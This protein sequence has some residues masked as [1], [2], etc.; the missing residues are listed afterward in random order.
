MFNY[1]I[2]YDII[3]FVIVFIC[4]EISSVFISDTV[5]YFWNLFNI[6]M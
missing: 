5:K 1:F 2:T 4:V 6:I 3:D